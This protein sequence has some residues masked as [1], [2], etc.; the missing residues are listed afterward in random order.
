MDIVLLVTCLAIRPLIVDLADVV[1]ANILLITRGV[2]SVTI[3][4]TWSK[5]AGTP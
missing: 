2:M 1:E 3:L 4:D 5:I